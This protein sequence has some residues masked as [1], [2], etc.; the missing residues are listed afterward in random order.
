MNII[1]AIRVIGQHLKD[2]F[3]FTRRDNVC[4]NDIEDLCAFVIKIAC[5][6]LGMVNSDASQDSNK[7]LEYH[8]FS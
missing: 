4:Y 1:S 2:K 3:G 7:Y 5:Q 6:A 8:I